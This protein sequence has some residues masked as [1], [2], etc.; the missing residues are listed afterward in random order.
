MWNTPVRFY[1]ENDWS[2][3][4]QR[5]NKSFLYFRHNL[6]CIFCPLQHHHS[7]PLTPPPPHTHT[8]TS[9]LFLNVADGDLQLQPRCL[10][11]SGS[12]P[13]PSGTS[14]EYTTKQKG[15]VLAKR[16]AKIRRATRDWGEHRDTGSSSSGDGQIIHDQ[17]WAGARPARPCESE[18]AI[19]QSCLINFF[20]FRGGRSPQAC[21]TQSGPSLTDGNSPRRGF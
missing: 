1:I 6:T 9:L 15:P 3:G 16:E 8:H 12:G 21:R 5:I 11:V 4:I 10:R 17:Q 18:V 19:L 20:I 13:E 7:T 2:E 14:S